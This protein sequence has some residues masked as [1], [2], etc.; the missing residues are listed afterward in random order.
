MVNEAAR[1]LES[2]LVR[3]PAEV[4]LA[5]VLGTG[6]PPFRGGLLRHADTIGLPAVVQSLSLLAQQHGTR[7]QPARLL[8]DLVQA[9]RGFFTE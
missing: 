3:S 6:F 9:G 8:L 4:D 1:C 5:M 2:S 7:F